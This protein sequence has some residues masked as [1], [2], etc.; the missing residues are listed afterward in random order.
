MTS[1]LLALMLPAQADDVQISGYVRPVFQGVYRPTAVPLDQREIRLG[2]SLGGVIFDGQVTDNWSFRSHLRLG[3]GTVSVLTGVGTVDTNNDGEVDGVVSSNGEAIGQIVREAAVTYSPIDE[4]SIRA[5]RLKVPFTSQAQASD[6]AL[7]F[8]ERAGPGRIFHADDD[9]GAL[10]LV[11]MADRVT[12]S[13]G[14]FN[15]EGMGVDPVD[16][17]GAVYMSRVD[18]HPFGS[19][20]FDESHPQG[21]DFRLGFGGGLIWHAYTAFDS[22]GYDNIFVGDLRASG[23][24]RLAVAGL[25]VSGEVLY[26]LQRDDLTDRPIQATGAFGQAGWRTPIGFEPIFRIGSL[27]EDQT[28]APRTTRWLE[29]GMNYYPQQ[30]SDDPNAIRYSVQYT[31]ENRITEQEVAHGIIALVQLIWN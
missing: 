26:R 31:G 10:M 25:S 2:T 6:T 22:A 29:G 9:L 19:F 1:L 24:V 15:G 14:V 8:S 30:Q 5:G 7:L 20:E 21:Q 17:R 11:N 12:T 4:L 18:V 27:I 23:S 13:L 3:V 28:F 16:T